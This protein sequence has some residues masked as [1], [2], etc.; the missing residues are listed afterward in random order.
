MF[1]GRVSTANI[2]QSSSKEGWLLSA[3]VYISRSQWYVDRDSSRSC[4]T[5]RKSP[6]GKMTRLSCSCRRHW[7]VSDRYPAVFVSCAVTIVLPLDRCCT[8]SLYQN[9]PGASRLGGCNSGIVHVEHHS[10]TVAVQI[11]CRT[12]SLLGQGIVWMAPCDWVMTRTQKL[13]Y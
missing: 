7:E 11:T 12:W 8:S 2:G 1:T 3:Y 6:L 5:C 9:E 10:N 4:G 13:I